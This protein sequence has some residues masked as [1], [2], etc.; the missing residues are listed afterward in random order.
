[1]LHGDLNLFTPMGFDK[2][3]AVDACELIR[4][5]SSKAWRI[6]RTISSRVQKF[7]SSFSGDGNFVLR[8]SC[9]IYE[10]QGK[11]VSN[12]R[13][14]T[15]SR[16]YIYKPRGNSVAVHF[17]DGRPFY[18]IDCSQLPEASFEHLCGRDTYTGKLTIGSQIWFSNWEVKGPH[19]NLEILS[20]YS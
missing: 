7:P 3:Q 11:L 20:S 9:W 17:E 5:L 10:E 13:T 16:R 19:K 18:S 1:M 12:D 15:A 4:F 8:G 14:Y 2:T 6:Q